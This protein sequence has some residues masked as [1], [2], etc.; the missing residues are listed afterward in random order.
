MQV[1]SFSSLSDRGLVR[2]NNEDAV[3]VDS[4]LAL[5][6]LADGMGGYNAGEVASAMAIAHIATELGSRAVGWGQAPQYAA[7]MGAVTQAVENASKAIWSA[8]Q[9][10]A[11]YNGM[12]TTVVVALFQHARLLLAHVG[13]SR[14]Y[15]WRGGQLL[16]LTR[17]HSFLQEQIDAGMLSADEA[18]TAPHRNLV[19]RALGVE[20]TVEVEIHGHDVFMGDLYLLCSDGLTDM[21]PDTAIAALLAE[22]GALEETSARLVQAA[23]VAGGRDNISVILVRA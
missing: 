18:F 16:Q 3:H 14:A 12:G 8:A 5:A 20:P 19:T 7:S 23:N 11:A 2:E 1:L 9:A 21:L 22:G 10:H 17:D 4:A 15:R 13:D 6:V